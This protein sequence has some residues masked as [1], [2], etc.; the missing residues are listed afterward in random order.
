M[1][2]DQFMK[3]FKYMQREFASVS[4]QFDDMREQFNVINK[5]MD[6]L[7]GDYD[8]MVDEEAAN[9]EKFNR[10]SDKV[11]EHDDQ[12]DRHAKA[13]QELHKACT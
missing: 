7:I 13:I 6:H 2:E 10:L 1:S 9:A 8:I 5:A 12:L 11:R 4:Q 3:L